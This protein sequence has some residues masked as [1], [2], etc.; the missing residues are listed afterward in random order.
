MWLSASSASSTNRSSKTSPTSRPTFQ[1]DSNP[2]PISPS[3]ALTEVLRKNPFRAGSRESLAVQV[4]ED[5]SV[6]LNKDLL[7]LADFFP[8]VK[9]EVLRELLL[10]FDGDSR[11]A[12]CTEQLYKYKT[13]WARGR[14]N[15][16]SRDL[17][18]PIPR[19]EQFRTA[20]YID[21]V[22]RTV[23]REFNSLN[24]SAIDAVLAEVNYSYTNARPTLQGLASKTWKIAITSIFKKKKAITEPPSILLEK[25]KS[26]SGGPHLLATGSEELDEDLSTVF[27]MP[28]PLQKPRDQQ[29]IDLELAEAINLQEA[30]DAGALFECQI[31]YNDT[32]FEKIAFCTQH[33]H[34]I[35][36]D[37]V[38]RTLNEAIFG[39]G[40]SKTVDVER[41]TLKCLAPSSDD[42]CEGCIP[43]ELVQRSISRE[44]SATETW[45]RFEDRLA[46]HAIQTSAITLTRCPFCSYAEADSSYE[47]ESA[48]QLTWHVRRP[49]DIS[50]IALILILELL[51]ALLFMTIPFLVLFPKFFSSYFYI[52]LGHLALRNRTSRFICRSLSCG[53]KSCLQCLKSWHD[54]HIC[55]EPLILSLR[56]T[57]EAAR[58][59]AIKRTCPRCGTSF[60]KSSGCNKLTCVCG[61]SMCYLCRK[62]I[63]KAGSN[64][65]GGEGYRHFCEHFRPTPGQKCQECDKCDLYRAEDE[66]AEVK[67]AGEEAERMWRE[68]EGMIG[69]KGLEDAVGNVAGEDSIFNRLREGRWSVQD[70]AD[71]IVEM[72]ITVD[73]D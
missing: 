44:K 33:N 19:D 71:W 5:V 20:K 37:C 18:E 55:H 73:I 66:D 41:G 12:L 25:T 8:D 27:T 17:D 36:L 31:C 64:T 65:E 30:E 3:S 70:V 60:V 15:V 56:T 63:G 69:V 61:Y 42:D 38:R 6:Q 4:E 28:G 21:A 14:L 50:T 1:A 52:A 72:F 46:E 32:T 57:V 7:I 34:T 45:A 26:E 58:T 40:W 23:R 67:R 68:R 9:V 29:A 47:A 11:L 53:R 22:K 54:P 48:S 16:P 51:P 24:R 35:C 43:R 39:Q 49:K 13:E 2:R 10:R 62:N 59:A